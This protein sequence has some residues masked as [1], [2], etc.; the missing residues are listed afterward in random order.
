MLVEVDGMDLEDDEVP[1]RFYRIMVK[2][3][4]DVSCVSVGKEQLSRPFQV[5]LA[6]HATGT[7]LHMSTP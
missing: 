1:R 2:K 3:R 6:K 5:K 4:D 7:V